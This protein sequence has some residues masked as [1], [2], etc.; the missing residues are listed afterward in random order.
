MN[1]DTTVSSQHTKFI[2][3]ASI[4]AEQQEDLLHT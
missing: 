3:D 2:K 1:R 4:K